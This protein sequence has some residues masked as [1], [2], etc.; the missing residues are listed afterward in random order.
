MRFSA[1]VYIAKW[2]PPIP[3]AFKVQRG[4]GYR[5]GGSMYTPKYH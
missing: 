5:A 2:K 3:K 1:T 4:Y